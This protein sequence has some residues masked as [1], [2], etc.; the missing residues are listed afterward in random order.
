VSLKRWFQGRKAAFKPLKGAYLGYLSSN[1][2]VLA[3]PTRVRPVHG[4]IFTIQARSK[5]EKPPNPCHFA[6][7]PAIRSIGLFLCGRLL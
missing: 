5:S 6:P 3:R 4:P 2:E 7:F 1:I